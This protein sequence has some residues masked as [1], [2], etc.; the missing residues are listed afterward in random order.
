M[1]VR[2]DRVARFMTLIEREAETL[3]ELQQRIAEGESL[4][5]ICLAWDVP[6]MRVLTWLM[7]DAERYQKY[8]RA[9]EVEAHALIAE[10][11]AIADRDSPFTQRDR[12]KVDTRFRKAQFHAPRMYAPKQEVTH[13]LGQSFTEALLEIS[14]RRALGGKQ[15]RVVNPGQSG[16]ASRAEPCTDAEMY[17]AVEHPPAVGSAPDDG[18]G[19]I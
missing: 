9:L 11:V 13:E 2:S 10:T 4:Q 19:E 6:Y 16:Q 17:G 14:R 1:A 12:L 15:E 18:E 3:E 8:L 7:A 5:T